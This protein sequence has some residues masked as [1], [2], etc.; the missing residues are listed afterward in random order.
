[1]GVCRSERNCSPRSVFD[2]YNWLMARIPYPEK[3]ITELQ[4]VID[5][6]MLHNLLQMVGHSEVFTKLSLSIGTT[7]PDLHVTPLERELSILI[8]AQA[9]DTQYEW[10]QH[11]PMA[12][13]LGVAD[14]QIAAITERNWTSDAF[15]DEQS[16]LV[17]FVDGIARHPRVDDETFSGFLAAHSHRKL[18]ELLYLNGMFFT[19]ARTATTLDVELDPESGIKWVKAS[20]DSG[21]QE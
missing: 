4:P 8:F 6:G 19:V 16:A 21:W 17:R 14:E 7:F 3:T 12:K 1:M 15:T 2:G 13:A 18:L 20:P 10:V 9:F 5:A 11:L